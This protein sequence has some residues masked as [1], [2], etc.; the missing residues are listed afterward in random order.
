VPPELI[1]PRVRIWQGD[2]FTDVPSAILRDRGYLVDNGNGRFQTVESLTESRD[3]QRYYPGLS[4]QRRGRAIV[5]THECEFDNR[6]RAT[7]IVAAVRDVSHMEPEDQQRA[8]AVGPQ[9][10]GRSFLPACRD[11][12]I[13]AYVD[14]GGMTTVSLEL[15]TTFDRVASM[16]HEARTIL[17]ADFFRFL[18]RRT[19][20][21][22]WAALLVPDD[23][24]RERP[25]DD[26][27]AVADAPNGERSHE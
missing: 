15:L 20:R 17:Q 18:A 25:E 27:P 24:A 6:Q 13:G 22:G 1:P 12:P 19:F 4:R 3:P 7:V 26:A 2:I 23:D 11:L 10:R 9:H 21:A 16:N 5:L 14:F 8:L